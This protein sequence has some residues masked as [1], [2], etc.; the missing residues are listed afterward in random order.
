MGKTWYDSLQTK[1]TKRLSHGLDLSYS[2]TWSKELQL[3]SESDA[4]GG[5]INDVFN[6]DTNKQLSSFSRPFWNILALNYTVPAWHVNPLVKYAV[7]DWTLGTTLQ[8]GS[9]QPI[10]VPTTAGNLT[11]LSQ[12]LGRGTRAER[13]QGVPLF[14][15]DLNCH[16]FDPAQTQ[17]LNP[18]AWRD[19]GSTYDATGK[20]LSY[21][22]SF[23]PSAAY[24]N[25]YRYRRIPRETLAFG[26]I[27][28]I[29]ERVSFQVRM[30]FTNPFN[31]TQVPNRSEETTS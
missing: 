17:V 23:S 3:G 2:F 31:R 4:G 9:G 14:L 11:N 26:R 15:T 22:G 5:L 1:L 20:Q 27:F 25:D 18:A 16:C 6:R 24:Y 10:P 30:E 19:P 13:I 21:D 8:Y 28:R 7:S 12:S 29:A